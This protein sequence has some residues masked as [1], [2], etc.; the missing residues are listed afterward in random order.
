MRAF[1]AFVICS[2]FAVSATA[3]GATPPSALGQAQRLSGL[4]AQRPIRT[5][6]ESSARFNAD[7]VRMLDRAYPRALQSTDDRLYAGL[8]LLP[9]GSSARARLVASATA[10]NALYDPA[11][12]VLRLRRK[13]APRSSPMC[14]RTASRRPSRGRS[15]IVANAASI[16]S[17][18]AL[19][20]SSTTMKPAG[21]VYVNRRAGATTG[22]P[23]DRFLSLERTAGLGPGRTF[24]LRLRSVGG[25]YAVS[26]ALRTFPQ[27]T[28]Q[29]LHLD[30]FLERTR[31][32]PIVLPSR[33]DNRALQT[34]ETLSVAETFGE[35]DVAAYLRGFALPRSDEIAAGW[36]GGRLALY[37]GTDNTETVA[38]VLRWDSAD[39]A[40]AWRSLAPALVLSAF[41]AAQERACPAVERC[42]VYGS[43]EIA[44][45]SVRDMTVLASGSAGELVAATIA[46]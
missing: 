5:V 10:S 36:G 41:P 35:L 7:A 32:L 33:V 11:A 9:T 28:E 13:P 26:T 6:T 16:D 34:S 40:A 8:G 23:L 46:R 20:A 14:P 17:G 21:V 30:A 1:V 25:A 4:H 19:Y 29:V 18:L 39:D 45:A 15:S 37:A 27:T 44:L 38:L 43:R 22:T 2:A 42:W 24:V 31:A 12:R 3:A